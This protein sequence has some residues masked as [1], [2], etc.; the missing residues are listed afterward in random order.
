MRFCD[1]DASGCDV[2]VD[3]GSGGLLENP[4]DIGFAQEKIRSQLFYRNILTDILI[5]IGED[6]IHLLTVFVI[7]YTVFSGIG[8]GEGIDHHQQFHEGSLLHNVMCVAPGRGHFTDIVEETLLLCLVQGNLVLKAAV[9]VG[10]AIIQI[11]VRC[12]DPLDEIRVDGQ[13]DPFMDA[14]VNLGQLVALV[15]VDDK[16]VPGRNGIKAIVN[17]ELLSAGDGVI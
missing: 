16:Q 5:D 15:L 14:V 4:A 3:G 7:A 10:K 9:P 13:H 17:Q 6:I 12:G 8:I 11:G 1:A 2:F